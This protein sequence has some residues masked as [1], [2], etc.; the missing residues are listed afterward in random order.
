MFQ[1]LDAKFSNFGP[2]HYDFTFMLGDKGINELDL[3]L[4]KHLIYYK[5]VPFAWFIVLNSLN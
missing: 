1:F 4:L 5:K 3:V 2:G